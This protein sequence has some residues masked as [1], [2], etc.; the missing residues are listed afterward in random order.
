MVKKKIHDKATERVN[1]SVAKDDLRIEVQTIFITA[2]L[3]Y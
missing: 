1:G 2:Y 3:I